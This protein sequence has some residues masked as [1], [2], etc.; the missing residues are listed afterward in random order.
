MLRTLTQCRDDTDPGE[1]VTAASKVGPLRVTRSVRHE[2]TGG[3]GSLSVT[4][5][6]HSFSRVTEKRR[7]GLPP[8]AASVVPSAAR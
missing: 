1:G 8:D 7:D 3:E 5:Y 6:L 2:W 4:V